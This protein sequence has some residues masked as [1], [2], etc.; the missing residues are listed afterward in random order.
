MAEPRRIVQEAF[1]SE[2]SRQNIVD[3]FAVRMELS[4]VM[5]NVFVTRI[6]QELKFGSIG[7]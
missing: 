4:N 3:D 6:A 5:S 2:Q 7:P 1:A